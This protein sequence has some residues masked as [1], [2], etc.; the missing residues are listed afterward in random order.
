MFAQTTVDISS[1]NT[2]ESERIL[3]SIVLILHPE[4]AIDQ[5]EA[6]VKPIVDLGGKSDVPVYCS[7]TTAIATHQRR[8]NGQ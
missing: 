1:V 6:S 4:L 7:S 8:P 2:V 3:P 5:S